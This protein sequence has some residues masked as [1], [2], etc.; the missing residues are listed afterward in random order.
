M[1]R[2]LDHLHSTL[3]FGHA[4]AG[5]VAARAFSTISLWWRLNWW[6]RMPSAVQH[7][8]IRERT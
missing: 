7:A 1:R 2:D 6:R 5:P 3:D 8:L 4:E